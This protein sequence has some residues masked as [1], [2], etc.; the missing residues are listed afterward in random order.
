[1]VATGLLLFPSLAVLADGI[2]TGHPCVFKLYRITSEVQKKAKDLLLKVVEFLMWY[3]W[4]IM[5]SHHHTFLQYVVTK[6]G[7]TCQPL[8]KG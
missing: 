1:M 4:I 6:V 3:S 7:L 5:S 8:S 2:G